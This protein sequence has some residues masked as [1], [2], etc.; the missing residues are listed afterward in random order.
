MFRRAPV[1]EPTKAV[2][3]RRDPWR[4]GILD[5]SPAQRFTYRGRLPVIEMTYS[6][7]SKLLGAEQMGDWKNTYTWSP[8]LDVGTIFKVAGSTCIGDAIIG[9][10]VKGGD[11]DERQVG[12]GFLTL[13]EKFVNSFR[14][15][16]T[17][18]QDY[19]I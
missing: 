4:P 14:P 2:E 10:V 18:V 6:Q 11:A 13:G 9:V 5:A 7:F 19:Q 17:D 8:E 15:V 16:L 1:E 12:G 3:E